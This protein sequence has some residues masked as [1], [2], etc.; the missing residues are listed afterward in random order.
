MKHATKLLSPKDIFATDEFAEVLSPL[1]EPADE[2]AS[3]VLVDQLKRLGFASERPTSLA[4]LK[5][6]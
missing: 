5:V 6:L 1:V 3:S 4:K 2:D